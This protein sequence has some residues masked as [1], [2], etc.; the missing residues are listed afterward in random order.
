MARIKR[1][2]LVDLHEAGNCV[3]QLNWVRQDWINP[4]QWTRLVAHS[5]EKKNWVRNKITRKNYLKC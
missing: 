5:S 3:F 1:I 4:C 2:R